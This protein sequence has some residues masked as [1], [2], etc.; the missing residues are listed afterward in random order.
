M[1]GRY[2]FNLQK[3]SKIQNDRLYEMFQKLYGSSEKIVMTPGC[4]APSFICENGRYH[5]VEMKWGF[6]APNSKLV[7][8]ARAE[9]LGDKT[10]FSK[11]SGCRRCAVPASGYYEWRKADKQKFSIVPADHTSIIYFAGLYRVE[12]D[13][14]HFTIVTQ[15]ASKEISKIHNRMPLMLCS[16]EA[17]GAW[18]HEAETENF[19]QN[20]ISLD[21]TAEGNEQL[22]MTFNSGFV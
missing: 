2:F 13:G 17:A 11:A 10:M 8:N 1:C 18:L 4:R 20:E 15:N 3:E 14:Y 19:L 7:F 21:I 12:S 22:A 9:T 5:D 6:T 16:N